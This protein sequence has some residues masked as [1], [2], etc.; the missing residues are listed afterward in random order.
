MLD[1]G[2]TKDTPFIGGK[3]IPRLGDQTRDRFSAGAARLDQ[4]GQTQLA[5]MPRDERLAEPDVVD[6]LG[7]RRLTLREPPHDSQA[8][9]VRQ[10][11]VNQSNGAE[12]LGLVNDRGDRGPDTSRR[13]AQERLRSV[14]AAIQGVGSMEVYINM[15]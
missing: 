11:L 4:T 6:E 3:A 5:Q 12:I 13:R 10:G 15:R 7:D 1:R 14:A 2:K 8:I 9:H